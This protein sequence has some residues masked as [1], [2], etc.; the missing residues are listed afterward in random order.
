MSSQFP[1]AVLALADGSLFEGFA[2]GAPGQ[3]TGEV[4]FNTALT[5]Y[6]EILTDPSYCQQLVTLTYPHIGNTGWNSE[7]NESAKV[8]AAGLIVRDLPQ[9]VSSFRSQQSL[10][11]ALRSAGI[12]AIAGI[13]TRALTRRLRE[14][15][16]Q[17]GAIVCAEGTGPVAGM[18]SLA[19]QAVMLARS[20]PGLVG[21][22]LAQKVSTQK[23]YRWTEGSWQLAS[24]MSGAPVPNAA[25][26]QSQPTPGAAAPHVVAYDFGIKYNILRLLVDRGATVT[27]VPAK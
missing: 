5:G 16:A 9:V 24:A 19:D 8:Q 3:T 6:Q 12:V 4:V 11:E 13:D 23:S 26:G 1:I 17:S 27:V 7:D 10:S 2:I 18:Q 21:A 20:F 14:T 15:G 22:D 25:S